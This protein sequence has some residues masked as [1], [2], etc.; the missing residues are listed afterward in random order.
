MASCP[1]RFVEAAR[2]AIDTRVIPIVGMGSD[3]RRSLP[4]KSMAVGERRSSEGSEPAGF[5]SI[6]SS[7]PRPGIKKSKVAKPEEARVCSDLKAI[8]LVVTRFSNAI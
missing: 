8:F 5:F 3:E 4:C 6:P 1:S 2:L 7:D